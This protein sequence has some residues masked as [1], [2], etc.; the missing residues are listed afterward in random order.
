[1]WPTS[2]LLCL[3]ENGLIQ[4]WADPEVLGVEVVQQWL[5]RANPSPLFGEQD[6][7]DDSG[8]LDDGIA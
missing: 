4:T 8:N 2:L 3:V 1:M 7:S 6:K 5:D